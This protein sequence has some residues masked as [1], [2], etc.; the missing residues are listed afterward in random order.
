MTER[1]PRAT[2]KIYHLADRIRLAGT[3]PAKALPPAP[4]P[5]EPLPSMPSGSGWYHDAAI[6]ETDPS[7]K[8]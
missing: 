4:I 8:S 6:R 3:R 5:A 1:Y 2:A 7:R